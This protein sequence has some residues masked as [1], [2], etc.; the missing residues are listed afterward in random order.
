MRARELRELL[1]QVAGGL[2]DDDEVYAID[3]AR[4]G[5]AGLLRVEGL[6]IFNMKKKGGVEAI[7]SCVMLRTRVV[8]DPPWEEECDAA[9]AAARGPQ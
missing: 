6:Q 8:G 2:A 5:V 1:M 4:P 9:V 3:A 7:R